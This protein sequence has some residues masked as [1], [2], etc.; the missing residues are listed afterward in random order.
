MCRC[1]E[2]IKELQAIEEEQKKIPE[3]KHILK[4]RLTSITRKKGIKKEIGVINFDSYEL[5]YCPECRKEVKR[6][7]NI[8]RKKKSLK[9]FQTIIC[10]SGYM[11][12]I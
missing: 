2:A 1:C 8:V 7:V 9:K 10:I 11:V 3:I 6:C 5:N 4:A 12:N